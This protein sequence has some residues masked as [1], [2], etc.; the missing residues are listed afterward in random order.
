MLRE[1]ELELERDT[2][3][4]ID[5]PLTDQTYDCGLITKKWCETLVEKEGMQMQTFGK[6]KHLL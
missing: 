6:N 1:T 2:A 3:A 4:A 5:R